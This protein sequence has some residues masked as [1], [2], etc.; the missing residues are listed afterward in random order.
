MRNISRQNRKYI[1]LKDFFFGSE[2]SVVEERLG[3]LAQPV[4]K[5]FE[6][7]YVSPWS[8]KTE[9]GPSSVLKYLLARTQNRMKLDDN[10]DTSRLIT[11]LSV[12]RAQCKNTRQPHCTWIG[13]ATC[14]YQTDGVFFLTD[15]VWSSRASPVQFAGPKR[16]VEPPIEIEDL[17]VDV[18]LLSHT[19][20]DH[21][22]LNS[23]K[24]I[25]NKAL[26]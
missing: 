14:Y 6:G 2:K 18:V 5:H 24:R 17:K 25:G 16:F 20:Y 12:D 8:S 7:R 1:S 9:K 26:W 10:I 19:H 4:C 11:S 15:P 3:T 23:A 22:D 13:H 21:L